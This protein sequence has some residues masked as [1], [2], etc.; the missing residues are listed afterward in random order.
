MNISIIGFLAIQIDGAMKIILE[1]Y[2]DCIPHNIFLRIVLPY[3][4][5]Q[6]SPQEL[7]LVC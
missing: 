6:G 1:K 7:L 2:T 5:L 3:S 4:L